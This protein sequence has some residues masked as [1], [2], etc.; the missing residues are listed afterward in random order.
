[1]PELGG[2]TVIN[3]AYGPL[4]PLNHLA[5][6]WSPL[7]CTP[8][9]LAKTSSQ[10]FWWVSAADLCLH[11]VDRIL[12]KWTVLHTRRKLHGKPPAKYVV[13]HNM[14]KQLQPHQDKKALVQQAHI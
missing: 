7:W 12:G 1:M 14:H 4:L 8:H 2:N 5:W 3:G 11:S 13:H 9:S 10:S 6:I